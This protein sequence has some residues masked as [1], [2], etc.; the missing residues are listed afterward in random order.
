MEVD[1]PSG[2]RLNI[3]NVYR[4]GWATFAKIPR[5]ISV[6]LSTKYIWW[7]DSGP[8]LRH[9]SSEDIVGIEGE[10]KIGPIHGITARLGGKRVQYCIE[11]SAGQLRNLKPIQDKAVI[12]GWKWDEG[13]GYGSWAC[14]RSSRE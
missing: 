10:T 3:D 7:H 2:L 1:F 12:K 13:R 11:D 14:F 8:H 4:D 5:L 6:E 9:V